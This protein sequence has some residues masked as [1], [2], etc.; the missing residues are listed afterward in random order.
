MS[1]DKICLLL[2]LTI[3]LFFVDIKKNDHYI[4][5]EWT[6]TG[7][8]K[9]NG[10]IVTSIDDISDFESFK[11]HVKL[12][13]MNCSDSFNMMFGLDYPF[14][15]DNDVF[16]MPQKIIDRYGFVKMYSVGTSH[17]AYVDSEDL[18]LDKH[19]TYY[20]HNIYLILQAFIELM[21]IVLF[22]VVALSAIDACT[23]AKK[24]EECDE[25]YKY[26]PISTIDPD[27]LNVPS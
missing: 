20:G 2:V 3:A 9:S 18:F 19:C 16:H 17:N 26:S 27:E 22:V 1:L 15:D 10:Q 14:Y 25:S 12:S 23:R 13:S 6:T 4:D 21:R 7:Y 11:V 8:E 5:A 24:Y